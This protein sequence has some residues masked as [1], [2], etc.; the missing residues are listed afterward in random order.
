MVECLKEEDTI[1]TLSV[2]TLAKRGLLDLYLQ[3]HCSRLPANEIDVSAINVDPK[4]SNPHS[5][6]HEEDLPSSWPIF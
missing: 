2:K 3:I 6:Q 1:E 4:R 5:R